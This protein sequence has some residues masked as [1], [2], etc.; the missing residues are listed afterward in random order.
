MAVAYYRHQG[1]HIDYTPAVTAVNAGDVLIIGS[2]CAIA[3][4][5]IPVGVLGS[6]TIEGAF[7][8]TLHV[9][10]TPKVGDTMY[11]DTS[12]LTASD[13]A[14]Y[15]NILGLCIGLA[16]EGNALMVRVL[17]NPFLQAAGAYGP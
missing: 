9:G 4:D 15:T 17:I 12:D 11:F 5:D 8:F 10:D 16:P 13:Q 3:T 1:R 2:F 6:L 14:T 7:D